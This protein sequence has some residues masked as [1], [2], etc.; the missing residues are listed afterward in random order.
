[1]IKK[2][3]GC[4]KN[5]EHHGKGYCYNCYRK[6]SWKPKKGIC[7]K[8]GREKHIHAKGVCPG[9][10]TTIFRLQYNKEWNHQKRHNI[11]IETYKKITKECIICGFNKVVDLHHLDENRDNNSRDNLTGLCPNHHKMF[12]HM[13][14][15]KEI[16][17]L[18]KEKGVLK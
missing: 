2:C 6:Y 3:K 13:G 5:E 1:M 18:L 12:H 15:R 10:Y 9:C 16:V 8:C 14:F 11:D 17:N 4:G 7:K